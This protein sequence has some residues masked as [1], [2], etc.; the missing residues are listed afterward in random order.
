[1]TTIKK[2]G[3]PT[4]TP[5]SPQPSLERLVE[6]VN[7]LQGATDQFQRAVRVFEFEQRMAAVET[8]LAKLGG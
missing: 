8:R 1:M 7:L 4:P 6:T 5:S 3:I 2:L